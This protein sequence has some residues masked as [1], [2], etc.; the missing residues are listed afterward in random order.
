MVVDDEAAILNI[1]GQTLQAFGYQVITASNG[2][3]AIALYARHREEIAVVLTDMMMP[4]MDGATTIFTLRQINPAVKVIGASGLE[5]NGK[6]T[7][8]DV[9]IKHFIEK[10]YTAESL[11]CML[12]E[13]LDS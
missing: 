12:R 3:E 1:T 9:E 11:L 6:A 10:P 5:T 8:S 2:S 4:I 7:A 13:V